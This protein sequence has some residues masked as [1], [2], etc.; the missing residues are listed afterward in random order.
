MFT[1]GKI[2][3]KKDRKNDYD[4]KCK[5][6]KNIVFFFFGKSLQVIFFIMN[7]FCFFFKTIFFFIDFFF[8]LQFNFLIQRHLK[9]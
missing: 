8:F 9:I 7:F 2:E 3:M 5:G 1:K 6:N 4:G